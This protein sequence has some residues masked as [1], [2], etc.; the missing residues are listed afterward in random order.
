MAV[1][2]YRVV[3]YDAPRSSTIV[4]KAMIRA[5][6]KADLHRQLRDWFY[7][8]GLDADDEDD[9]LLVEWLWEPTTQPAP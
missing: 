9:Q 1:E 3:Q 2:Q 4:A 8:Q 5:R 7:L 6:S